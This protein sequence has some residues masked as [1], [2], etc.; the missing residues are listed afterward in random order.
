MPNTYF[1]TLFKDFKK[2]IESESENN[3]KNKLDKN[4]LTQKSPMRKIKSEEDFVK[5]QV[6]WIL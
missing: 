2:I 5:L 1:I 6:P 3:Y 4:I